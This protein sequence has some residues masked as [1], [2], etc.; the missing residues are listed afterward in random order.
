MCHCFL[1][2]VPE[3]SRKEYF[4]RNHYGSKWSKKALWKRKINGKTLGPD[5]MPVGFSSIP[6]SNSAKGTAGC[7]TIQLNSYSIDLEGS[8][9]PGCPHFRCQSKVQ[10]VT[11]ASVH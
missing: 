9:P 4:I 11:W 8:V 1:E 2:T 7:S 10:G 5:L 6:P 3:K